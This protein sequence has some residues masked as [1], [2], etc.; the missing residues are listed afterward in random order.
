MRRATALA[1]AAR[2]VRRL[3]SW[4]AK[5]EAARGGPLAARQALGSELAGVFQL[6]QDAAEAA[7][8]ETE[9]GAPP[10]SQLTFVLSVEGTAVA[11]IRAGLLQ[12]S[13][14]LLIGTQCDPALSYS[15]V[16]PPLVSAAVDELRTR[17]AQRV[18]AVAPLTG[19]CGW[20]VEHELWKSLDTDRPD[21]DEEQPGAVE[22]VARGVP[23]PGHSV[24]GHGTFKAAR[25]AFEDLAKAYVAKTATDPDA[26]V[27]MFQAAGA[28][29][30]GIN[31]M[32]A[33]DPDALK[34]C[35]GCTVHLRFPEPTS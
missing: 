16:G 5:F 25:P 11:I 34:D 10:G 26:E 33:T 6:E 13:T 29:V 2:S 3:G 20:V 12:G 32:Q 14:G 31:W 35:A 17:G 4:A 22:A 30:L 21:Y 15:N 1:T 23:R 9:A 19:L 24:L 27:A 8:M 28:E 18:L 7:T